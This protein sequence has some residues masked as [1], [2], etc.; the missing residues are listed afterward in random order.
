MS[1]ACHD[2]AEQLTVYHS[3]ILNGT[4]HPDSHAV[5]LKIFSSGSGRRPSDASSKMFWGKGG[6]SAIDPLQLKPLNC[7]YVHAGT[8]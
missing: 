6:T 5:I 2:G 7:S 3:K 4:K 1:E 8:Q